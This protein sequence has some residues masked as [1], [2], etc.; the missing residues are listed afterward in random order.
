MPSKWQLS[1]FTPSS[2]TVLHTQISQMRTWDLDR[3][4]NFPNVTEQVCKSCWELKLVL[5]APIEPHLINYYN[6]FPRIPTEFSIF[7]ERK[8]LHHWSI[9]KSCLNWFQWGTIWMH[10]V[11]IHI[12]ATIIQMFCPANNRALKGLWGC[13]LRGKLTQGTLSSLT[14]RQFR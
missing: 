11:Q 7:L 10:W 8:F 13:M 1:L 4:N 5:S 6:H 3:A 9:I 12:P 14:C 2:L